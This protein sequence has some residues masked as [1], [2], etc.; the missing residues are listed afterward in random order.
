M[1]LLSR[2]TCSVVGDIVHP[3]LLNRVYVTVPVGTVPLTKPPSVAVSY[4]DAPVTSAPLHTALVLASKTAVLSVVIFGPSADA[5][6]DP[7]MI[8]A[9]AITVADA[10]TIARR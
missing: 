5:R 10:T 4:A 7:T 6:R 3:E 2:V 1:P 8:R 9:P